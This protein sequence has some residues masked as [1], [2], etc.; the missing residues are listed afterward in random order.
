MTGLCAVSV[1]HFQF[2]STY[3]Y[4][5]P[6]TVLCSVVQWA[7]QPYCLMAVGRMD[8]GLRLERDNEEFSNVGR[9]KKVLR[10]FLLFFFPEKFISLLGW[11]DGDG[12]GCS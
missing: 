12:V 1:A 6:Y 3:C 5:V 4:D 10:I 7:L 11:R 8:S 2:S 9:M